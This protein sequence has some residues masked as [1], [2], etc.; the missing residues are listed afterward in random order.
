MKLDVK[1]P[2]TLKRMMIDQKLQQ[3]LSE[4]HLIKQT[5]LITDAISYQQQNANNSNQ[6]KVPNLYH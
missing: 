1:E 4:Q 5:C 2:P 6:S 3:N